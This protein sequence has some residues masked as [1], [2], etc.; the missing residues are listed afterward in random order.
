[1]RRT[2]VNKTASGLASKAID[3]IG[4][5]ADKVKSGISGASAAAKGV[6]SSPA[7]PYLSYPIHADLSS[8]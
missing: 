7:F 4:K 3:G 6:R 8:S 1:M 2:Q 5:A